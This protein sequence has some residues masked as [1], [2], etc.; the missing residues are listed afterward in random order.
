MSHSARDSWPDLW[1]AQGAS[2]LVA[3]WIQLLGVLTALVAGVIA[4]RA[5]YRTRPRLGNERRC[6]PG[7][8][9]WRPDRDQRVVVDGAASLQLASATDKPGSPSTK[10]E[11][12]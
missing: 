7:S 9:G 11:G 3:S 5:N 4:T 8:C 6:S 2:V 12:K 10:E 1:G